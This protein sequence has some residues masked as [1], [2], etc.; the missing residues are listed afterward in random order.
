M[1]SQR[2]IESDNKKHV[3]KE[4]VIGETGGSRKVKGR[5]LM[6]ETNIIF[7]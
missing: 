3:F 1:E 7:N 6:V 2:R 5:F 4:L